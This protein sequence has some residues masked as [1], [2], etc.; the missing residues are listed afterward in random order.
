MTD[1]QQA[2]VSLSVRQIDHVTLV[3]SD[4]ERTRKFY[5]DI[6]GMHHVQRPKFSFP[7]MWFEAG[8]TQIHATQTDENSG[9]A[10]WVDQG[11]KQASRGHHFGFEVD[12]A[13]AAV[14]VLARYGIELVSGP[15]NRPDG[16]LQIYLH[17]PDGHLVELF[18][19]EK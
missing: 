7:G 5:C 19:L 12:D 10:G 8:S 13:Q 3:V 6:L 14:S 4:L 9:A 2:P 1:S 16:P 18:S 17:D 15:K 11:A